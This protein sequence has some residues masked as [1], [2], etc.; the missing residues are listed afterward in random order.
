MNIEWKC[1]YE[2]VNLQEQYAGIREIAFCKHPDE[3]FVH[4]VVAETR[5]VRLIQHFS[6]YVN[7]LE[8]VKE[9]GPIHSTNMEIPWATIEVAQGA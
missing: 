1:D 4:A 8:A 6:N 3:T 7:K 5:I 9:Y 2:L